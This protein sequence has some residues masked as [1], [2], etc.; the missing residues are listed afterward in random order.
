MRTPKSA[1]R[2][3]VAT[4]SV[5]LAATL[6]PSLLL[7]P[8]EVAAQGLTLTGSWRHLDLS[9]ERE[10]R[11]QAI[12][13]ATESMGMFTRGG[14][15]SRLRDATAPA[16]ELT[17]QD[18]G[19]RVTLVTN[20]RRVVLTTD[21]ASARVSGEAGEGVMQATRRDGRL[22]VTVRS[23]GSTRATVYRLSP[24]GARLTLEVSLTN[25]RLSGPM[26]YRVTYARR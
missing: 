22:H 2:A 8:R 5:A 12:D 26:T 20:G 21:G 17:I 19:E 13:R 7:A 4:L 1:G 25:E 10:S 9:E 6:P 18:E 14:A 11:L 15:R 24:D 16:S 3:L 23:D